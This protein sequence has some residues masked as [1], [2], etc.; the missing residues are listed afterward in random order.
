MNT[1]PLFRLDACREAI[2]WAR[3]QSDEATAWRACER[4]DWMLWLLG[5][6]SGKPGG[7]GRKRLVLACCD[8]AELV[9]AHVPAGEERPRKAI[10]TAR[11]WARGEGATLDDVR[12]AADAAYPA[13]PAYAAA[14]ADAAAAAA[15]AA[16][17]AAYPA[18]AAGAA[19]AAAAAA[20]ESTLSRCADI[21]RTHYPE[22]PELT[23]E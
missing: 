5:K 10:E 11:S 16:V 21:V 9:L 6:L 8:C 15:D 2:D 12:R 1:E 20:R 22:P 19:A 13:Y 18:D 14:A 17:Y 7:E 4:G 23:D 3:A